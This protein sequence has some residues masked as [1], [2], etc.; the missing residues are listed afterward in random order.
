MK[1][2]VIVALVLVLLVILAAAIYRP[3]EDHTIQDPVMLSVPRH[4]PDSLRECLSHY[5]IPF[6]IDG[7]GSLYVDTSDVDRAVTHCS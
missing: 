6:I 3:K 1:R 2:V 7:E 5:D 4:S